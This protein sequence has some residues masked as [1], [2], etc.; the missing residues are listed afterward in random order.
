MPQF[1]LH[2]VAGCG[3]RTPVTATGAGDPSLPKVCP[4]CGEPIVVMDVPLAKA[5]DGYNP[6][7]GTPTAQVVGIQARRKAAFK[8]AKHQ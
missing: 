3:N 7:D 8:T 2:C 1:Y 6:N 5:H 4:N